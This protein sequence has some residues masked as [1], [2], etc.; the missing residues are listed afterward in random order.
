MFIYNNV[1]LVSHLQG[2]KRPKAYVAAQGCNKFTIQD[3]WRLVW[4]LNTGRIIMAT[5]LV[6]NG[7]VRTVTCL[8]FIGPK[9]L[10]YF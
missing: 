2:Y 9:V 10:Q 1:V 5:N 8:H 6:E 3:M 7:K 4:Q